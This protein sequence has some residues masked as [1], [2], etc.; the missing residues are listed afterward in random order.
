MFP[1]EVIIIIVLKWTLQTTNNFFLLR[2]YF[3]SLKV[4][5]CLMLALIKLVYDLLLV[6]LSLHV[7]LAL[8][9]SY[10][11]IFYISKLFFYAYFQISFCLSYTYLFAM[12]HKPVLLKK[13]SN[14]LGKYRC[15]KKQR[16]HYKC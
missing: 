5:V 3:P 15:K 13:A 7:L 16:L 6:S 1:Y 2:G 8:I 4:L 11:S 14:K 12:D 10:F 9:F